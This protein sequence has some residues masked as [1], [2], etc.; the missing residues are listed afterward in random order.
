MATHDTVKGLGAKLETSNAGTRQVLEQL[1]DKVQDLSGWSTEQSETS[2]AMLV[3]LKQLVSGKSQLL[4][5]ASGTASASN[6]RNAR[7]VEESTET[8]DEDEDG[9]RECLDRLCRLAEETDRTV[10]SEDAETIVDDL[11][12]LLDLLSKAGKHSRKDK[13][14][15]RRRESH[16]GATNDE[17]LKNQREVKRM[18]GILSASQ[19]ISL[20]GRGT[21]PTNPLMRIMWT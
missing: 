19:C 9:I 12:S 18:K 7:N 20:N 13:K 10:Y 16:D 17:A 15:K 5:A 2:N 14:G 8:S 3:L 6:N 1:G 4:D 21:D 11:Q